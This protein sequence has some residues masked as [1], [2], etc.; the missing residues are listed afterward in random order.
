M[1]TFIRKTSEE[2]PSDLILL[3]R[4]FAPWV[5]KSIADFLFLM[6]KG[7]RWN[8]DIGGVKSTWDRNGN[9]HA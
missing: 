8:Y 7:W 9:V 6:K 5:V 3:N 2:V 4:S 1:I